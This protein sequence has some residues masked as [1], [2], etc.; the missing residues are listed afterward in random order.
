MSSRLQFNLAILALVLTVLGVGHLVG[1]ID[2][3]VKNRDAP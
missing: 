2:R 1:V 3:L